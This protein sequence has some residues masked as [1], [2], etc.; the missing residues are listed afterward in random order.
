MNKGALD[1]PILISSYALP[2]RHWEPNGTAAH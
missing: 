2:G 1:R